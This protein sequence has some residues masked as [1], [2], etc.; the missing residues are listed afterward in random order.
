MNKM[1]FTFIYDRFGYMLQY[2]KRPIGGSGILRSTRVTGR[3]ARENCKLFFR[4]AVSEIEAILSGRGS[5][6]MLDAIH[7]IDESNEMEMFALNNL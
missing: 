2:K 3:Y 4:L 5:K 6:Y 1:D 7:R